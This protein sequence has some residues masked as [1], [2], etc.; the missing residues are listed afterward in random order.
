MEKNR[1]I[2]L[3]KKASSA[4]GG[5]LRNTRLGRSTPR[6]LATRESMHLVLRSTRAKGAMSLLKPRN[7]WLV[8]SIIA[9]FSF[10]YGVRI[11]SMANVGNHLHLHIRLTGR[12]G[13]KP[14][15]RAITGAIAIGVTGKNRWSKTSGSGANAGN[16]SG[17]GANA[18]NGAGSGNGEN[19]ADG[20][21]WSG[22]PFTRIVHGFH[23]ARKLSE[24][25]RINQFESW[26]FSKKE[27]RDMLAVELKI[28]RGE[29]AMQSG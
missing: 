14:F 3:F 9:K 13:Y 7:A 6:P 17:S 29:T 19:V 28:L 11:L 1:Q 18:G 5:S 16:G 27:A 10:I 15:I 23:G 8:D 12:Q 2:S 21:F 4:Y 25:V 22:R 26:G 20:K 24:Y